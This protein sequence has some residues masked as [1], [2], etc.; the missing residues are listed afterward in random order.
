MDTHIYKLLLTMVKAM[1]VNRNLYNFLYGNNIPP[2]LSNI[3]L[4][5][6]AENPFVRFFPGTGGG[7]GGGRGGKYM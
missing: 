7:G 3:C 5:L 6:S 2:L 1:F 4:D